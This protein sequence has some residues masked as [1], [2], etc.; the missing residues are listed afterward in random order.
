MLGKG[1]GALYLPAP[2]A[3]ERRNSVASRFMI[4]S[5][6]EP[7]ASDDGER[8][9]RQGVLKEVLKGAVVEEVLGFEV[10][11]ERAVGARAQSGVE[12]ELRALEGR[13][14]LVA[15]HGGGEARFGV[16]LEAVAAPGDPEEEA[17]RGAIG[18]RLVLRGAGGEVSCLEKAVRSFREE[19]CRQRQDDLQL[20]SGDARVADVEGLHL[21]RRKQLVDDQ[22]AVRGPEEPG[23]H[24]QPLAPPACAGVDRPGALGPQR[25]VG[26]DAALIEV[27]LAEARRSEGESPAG[28]QLD[29]AGR[30]GPRE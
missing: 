30:P 11:P 17:V 14:V 27:E 4:L 21:R 10:E 1:A 16:A 7:S 25:R 13:A 29:R 22:V 5:W 18:E 26:G 12:E 20:R 3:R 6:L 8:K 28:A 15:R 19:A 24:R 23:A 9:A 2:Q